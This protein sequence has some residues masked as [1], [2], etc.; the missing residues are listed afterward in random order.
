MKFIVEITHHT[1]IDRIDLLDAIIAGG[2]FT[3]VNVKPFDLEPGRVATLEQENAELRMKIDD[4][5]TTIRQHMLGRTE[6]T[7]E[8]HS[9]CQVG[10]CKR[11]LGHAGHHGGTR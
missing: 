7:V 5:D 11:D 1:T 6:T 4:R 9:R 3:G 8:Q 10:S 2:S